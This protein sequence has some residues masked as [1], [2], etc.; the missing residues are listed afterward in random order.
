MSPF[1]PLTFFIIALGLLFVAAYYLSAILTPFLLGAI[2]AYLANPAVKGL[3]R[4]GLPHTVSVIS[5]FVLIFGLL[6]IA[7]VSIL[8]IIQ[9]QVV[10]LIQEA[11]KIIT[12]AQD[13]LLPWLQESVDTSSLTSSLSAGLPKAG[14]VFGALLHSGSSIIDALVS[15]VLTPVVT[16]Y[17]LRDWHGIITNIRSLLPRSIEPTVVGL[18]QECDE[19]LGAFFRGQ[20]LIMLALCLIYSTG[21]YFVGLQ[22]GIIIGL[23]GGL[24]SIVPYLGSIFVVVAATI[25]SLVQVGNWHTVACVLAVYAFGQI[26]EGYV[27]TPYLI[28]DRIGLHPVAVI[29]AVMAGGALFGFFGVLLA[30]P[31]AAILMVFARYL[32]TQYESSSLYASGR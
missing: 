8:P 24:L 18:I 32:I 15:L 23:I 21:L 27:L 11:P 22:L 14:W 4:R 20:L 6:T 5:I 19:V 17:L 12:W 7:I 16:F 28:G 13:R 29:F 1:R 25:A 9:Q 10:I 3:E 31:V 26:I 30:L 2:L